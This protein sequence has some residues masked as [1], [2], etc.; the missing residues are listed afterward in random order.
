M[1]NNWFNSNLPTTSLWQKTDKMLIP[2]LDVGTKSVYFIYYLSTD[3]LWHQV[4][5]TKK[6]FRVHC[7]I[8]EFCWTLNILWILQFFVPYTRLHNYHVEFWFFYFSILFSRTIYLFILDTLKV[9][10]LS[11]V[12]I[13]FIKKKKNKILFIKTVIK[14]W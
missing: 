5:F 4:I 3:F 14:E 10:D 1:N 7:K 12:I 8:F 2:P 13:T 9:L 6:C 11:S